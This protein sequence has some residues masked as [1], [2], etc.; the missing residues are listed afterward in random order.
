MNSRF[1]DMLKS[2]FHRLTV[3]VSFIGVLWVIQ[4]INATLFHYG[5]NQYGV[6][7]RTEHG[8]WGVLFASFLHGS[9]DHLIGNSIMLLLLSWVICFYNTRIWWKSIIFGMLIGGGITWL[10]GS[11]SYHIGASILVFSLWGTILGLAI[12]NRHPFFILAAL[13]LSATYGLSFIFGLIPQQ[14]ISFAGH[15]GGLIAGFACAKQLHYN[16]IRHQE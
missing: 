10:V 3:P 6:Y 11:P 7:P 14:G 9:Y 4:I 16:G 13:I 15:F 8:L 12:F 2:A 1:S 5:L